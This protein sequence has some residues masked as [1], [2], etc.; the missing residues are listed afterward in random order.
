[1]GGFTET[2]GSFFAGAATAG[3]DSIAPKYLP[4]NVG[5]AA[6]VIR[7]V[8]IVSKMIMREVRII[9]G[10]LNCQWWWWNVADS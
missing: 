7:L 5:S 1:M 10:L 3:R 9:A 2:P 8:A 4:A 6:S